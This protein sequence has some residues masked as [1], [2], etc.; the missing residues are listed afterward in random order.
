MLFVCFILPAISIE[1]N[2]NHDPLWGRLQWIKNE[3]THLISFLIFSTIQINHIDSKAGAQNS[4]L[5]MALNIFTASTL[6]TKIP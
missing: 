5:I 3:L 2:K 1:K 4:T 6:G